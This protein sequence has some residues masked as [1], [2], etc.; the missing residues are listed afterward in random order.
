MIASCRLISEAVAP[1][2]T[3]NEPP[4]LRRFALVGVVR[5]KARTFPVAPDLGESDVVVIGGG[6]TGLLTTWG[7]KAAGRTVVLLEAGRLGAGDSLAASGLSGLLVSSDYRAL[8]SMHGRRVARTLMSSVA[9]AG[10]AMSRGSGR[11]KRWS[12]TSR[13]RS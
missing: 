3:P 4:A 8:E 5:R 13:D 2:R 12:S 10:P 11:P 9:A 7:L 6:L 1:E